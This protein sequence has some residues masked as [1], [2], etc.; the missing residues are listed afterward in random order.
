MSKLKIAYRNKWVTIRRVSVT[1]NCVV[2]ADTVFINKYM[3][4]RRNNHVNRE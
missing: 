2:V 1:I 4:E 3:D